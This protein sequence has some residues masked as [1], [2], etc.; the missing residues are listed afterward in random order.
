[1]AQGLISYDAAN[2]RVYTQEDYETHSHRVGEGAAGFSIISDFKAGFV[3]VAIDNDQLSNS[4]R[5][6]FVHTFRIL[7]NTH[8]RILLEY[9]IQQ[10]SA[11]TPPHTHPPPP[12]PYAPT[13]TYTTPLQVHD[14][15]QQHFPHMHLRPDAKRTNVCAARHPKE[16]HISPTSHYG[17]VRLPSMQTMC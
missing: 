10:M 17:C 13:Q 15:I 14:I 16:R 8:P 11:A 2:E 12:P 3:Y 9:R 1:M 6:A 4:V 7:G 5:V